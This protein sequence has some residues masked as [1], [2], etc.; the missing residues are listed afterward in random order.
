[1]PPRPR[2]VAERIKSAVVVDENGCWRWQRSLNANGYGRIG[3]YA[4]GPQYAHR[5][6]YETFVGPIP[7]GLA[8]DHLCRVRDCVN[9]EH[10]EP[11]TNRENLLRG[12]GFAARYAAT[13]HC[14]QGHPYDE[15]NTYY[16]PGRGGRN[17]R[18]CGV[19]RAR[20]ARSVAA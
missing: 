3:F 5:V 10:L 4:R 13:T 8:I 14:P 2:P 1:M 16:R 19:D 18:R 20:A 9:P 11:V 12:I 7:E 15:A 6:S 17:C